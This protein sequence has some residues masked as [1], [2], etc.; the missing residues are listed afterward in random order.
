MKRIGMMVPRRKR[1]LHKVQLGANIHIT[2]LKQLKL[3]LLAMLLLLFQG[4]FSI[5][6]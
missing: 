6:S 1:V 2:Y 3:I 4:D 5:G